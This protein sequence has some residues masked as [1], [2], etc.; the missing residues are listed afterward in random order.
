MEKHGSP[1]PP[2]AGG[3][4]F[5]AGIGVT[6][7]IWTA[8]ATSGELGVAVLTLVVAVASLAVAVVRGSPR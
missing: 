8:F 5:L 1:T 3:M 7:T 4:G 2:V 6:S